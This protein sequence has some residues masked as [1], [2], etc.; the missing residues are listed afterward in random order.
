MFPH[1]LKFSLRKGKKT[2][3][4]CRSLTFLFSLHGRRSLISF[5]LFHTC[6]DARTCPSFILAYRDNHFREKTQ[7]VTKKK[8]QTIPL[9]LAFTCTT[10]S[11]WT[12]RN[13]NRARNASHNRP[14]CLK[15]TSDQVHTSHLVWPSNH[16][17]RT[18]Q[19]SPPHRQTPASLTLEAPAHPRGVAIYPGTLPI[20]QPLT[21]HR[22]QA[23]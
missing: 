6:I 7:T 11:L 4:N 1:L 13:H 15:H 12:I 20:S 10:T 14:P 5:S 21:L 22:S 16:S 2:H 18:A 9:T 19:P 23:S 8:D 17:S 3:K